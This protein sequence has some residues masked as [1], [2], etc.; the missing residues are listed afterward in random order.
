V[1]PTQGLLHLAS[2][3]PSNIKMGLERVRLALDLLGNPERRVPALHVAGT[4]G[5]GST[6][7]VAAECLQQRYRVGLYTSPHLVRVNERFR[8]DGVDVTDEVLGRRVAEVVEVLGEAHGLTF[9]ELG[10]IVAFW[11]FAQEQVE[12]AVLETGLGGR[13]DATNACAP[14]VTCVTPI[15][16]DHQE[17]LGTTLGAIAAEKAGIVK[18]GTPLVISA[19]VPEVMAVL[20]AASPELSVEGTD[21]RVE[22]STFIGG[23]WRID[24]LCSPLRGPHQR[25]NLAVALA[26]LEAL[27][28]RGFPLSSDEVRA[29]VAVTHWPGRLEE[30]AGPP[31]IVLDGAHNPAG[32]AA[33]MQALDV[34]YPGRPVQ[35]VFG[36]FADKDSE[37]MMGALFP[38]CAVLHLT[39]LDNVRSRAPAG[40]EP[41]A[42]ALCSS[43]MVH[44]SAKAA[45]TAARASCPAEGLVLVTGSLFLVGQVRALLLGEGALTA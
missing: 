45:L 43:V 14:L 33:L 32:V 15:S 19:Q 37:P 16:L 39:P 8:V 10:T 28:A 26:C 23:R 44:G 30:V 31:M 36:V 27:E 29:G 20:R 2:L 1:T 9:F 21:F 13:L 11:H 38:R 4:N 40:Y 41:L 17:Y 5:K 24:G 34:V 7:A 6:C 42:R 35:L 25:Q 18:P 3:P 12:L 22:D